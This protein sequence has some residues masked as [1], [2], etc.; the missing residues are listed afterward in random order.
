[1]DEMEQSQQTATETVRAGAHILC[2]E[3]E[4]TGLAQPGEGMVSGGAQSSL[5][6]PVPGPSPRQALDPRCRQ[7][8]F[9]LFWLPSWTSWTGGTQLVAS[10]GNHQS[11]NRSCC[12]HQGCPA[13][14]LQG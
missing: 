5:P 10:S 13:L 3:A 14:V 7:S 12:Y 2:A 8:S 1:M 11:V 6:R 4:R 9:L